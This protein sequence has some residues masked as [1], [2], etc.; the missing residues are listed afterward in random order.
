MPD[1][2]GDRLLVLPDRFEQVLVVVTSPPLLTGHVDYVQPLH[3]GADTR[4][5]ASPRRRWWTRMRWALTA[6]RPP[7]RRGREPRT[8]S[9]PT[10]CRGR[11]AAPS[12][13]P[14]L[15]DDIVVVLVHLT[16][17][18]VSSSPS[19]RLGRSRVSTSRPEDQESPLSKA[20]RNS[21]RPQRRAPLGSNPPH[22]RPERRQGPW[23]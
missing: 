1:R 19:T 6:A 8:A 5:G 2:G 9:A 15:V 18:V 7:A 10:S 22:P 12:V 20:W 14:L 11:I 16:P 3:P 23:S 13:P 17:S 4:P 21:A